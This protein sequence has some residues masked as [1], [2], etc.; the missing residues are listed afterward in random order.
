MK[1][2]Y[3]EI[4]PVA[5]RL[6][7]ELE[8]MP[9]DL[10]RG[11]K[12][13][14]NG[15]AIGLL[16]AAVAMQLGVHPVEIRTDPAHA[17]VRIHGPSARLGGTRYVWQGEH[18]A[19]VTAPGYLSMDVQWETPRYLLSVTLTPEPEPVPTGSLSVI[20]SPE[21]P[22][23]VLVDGEMRGASPLLLPDITAGR[24]VVEVRSEGFLP[25]REEVEIRADETTEITVA[26]ERPARVLLLRST[27]AGA[28]VL[29]AGNHVGRTPVRLEERE[30]AKIEATLLLPGHETVTR[31]F[32]L[33]PEPTDVTV[34][35]SPRTG[36][37]TIRTKPADATVLVDGKPASGDSLRLTQTAHLVEIRAP[38]YQAQKHT[39]FPHPD[40]DKRLVVSLEAES[41]VRL[42]NRTRH[43]QD[44]GLRFLRFRPKPGEVFYLETTRRRVPQALSRP[45]AI[46]DREVSNEL[47]RK[48]K[49][50]HDSGKF[51]SSS[52]N[53]PG[54]P[55]VR[56]SW[57]DA[58]RFANWMSE[59]AGIA[60]FYLERDGAITGFRASST[61][62]RLPSEAEWIYLTA[63]T[64]RF[65]W[66]EAWPPPP[67]SGNLADDSALEILA[68]VADDYRDGYPVSAPVASFAADAQ[69]LYDLPG[70]VAEWMHNVFAQQLR[71]G[72]QA[73]EAETDP[74]GVASGSLHIIR[75]FGWRD[76]NP[77]NLLR[78][79]RNYSE[80]A[81]VDVG[82][83]L[84]Y[85]PE[86]GP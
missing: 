8:P 77:R 12:I 10:P 30:V 26:L 33:G 2:S 85:Y 32:P 43:E 31:T 78:T 23:Q 79:A 54:Q 27:P 81:R 20:T 71:F 52:L 70:N 58:A 17:Q 22:A 11:R 21:G 59:Q 4:R 16:F 48:W 69:G 15:L 51:G 66:G 53:E 39:V 60:P 73:Q 34:S 75:G 57:N 55:A 3:R 1:Y 35:L 65:A 29:V 19:T 46:L 72:A 44:L 47:F 62:Y 68:T 24:R 64:G 41:R 61:G 50:D 9:P 7:G 40:I 63:G 67:G 80:K 49:A 37:V 5:F 38:G 84:A 25:H 18:A 82:F 86:E 28:D 6:R 14:Y 83:R 36:T 45:F 74:L 42:R 56:V 76:A 13:L